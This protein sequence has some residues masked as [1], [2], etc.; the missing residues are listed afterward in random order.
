MSKPRAETGP[1]QF[2]DDWP[3]VFIRGDNALALSINLEH[4]ASFLEGNPGARAPAHMISRLRSAARLLAKCDAR[5][6]PTC[7]YAEIA[8]P[9]QPADAL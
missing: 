1:M 7:Q 4:I 5:S 2:G 9:T 3:G 6:E 8:L